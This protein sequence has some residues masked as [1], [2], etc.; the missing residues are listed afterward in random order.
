MEIKVFD[1]LKNNFLIYN[2]LKTMSLEISLTTPQKI[3]PS[4]FPQNNI[5]LNYVHTLKTNIWFFIPFTRIRP[6]CN[7]LATYYSRFM[8]NHLLDQYL[9][10]F[11]QHYEIPHN[12]YDYLLLQFLL[13]CFIM[14]NISLVV[15]LATLHCV[16]TK[17]IIQFY[18]LLNVKKSA[19]LWLHRSMMMLMSRMWMSLVLNL[20]PELSF[21]TFESD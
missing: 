11:H 13:E 9:Y 21:E 7:S 16:P 3:H 2:F 10:Y 15:H 4:I 8:F 12:Y 5:H 1:L 18:S 20:S 19:K 17:V 14:M 6:V